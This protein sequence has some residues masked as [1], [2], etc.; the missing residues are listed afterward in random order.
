[1]FRSIK[2]RIY[3]SSSPA[4]Q[5]Q[6]WGWPAKAAAACAV[7][8]GALYAPAALAT[9]ICTNG[10]MVKESNWVVTSSLAG[11]ANNVSIANA[12]FSQTTSV[13]QAVIGNQVYL[14]I[15]RPPAGAYQTI[16]LDTFPGLGLRLSFAGYVNAGS[17]DLSPNGFNSLVNTVIANPVANFGTSNFSTGTAATSRY[18]KFLWRMDLVVTDVRVYAGGTGDFMRENNLS[19][20]MTSVIPIIYDGITRQSCYNT[21]VSFQKALAAGGVIALPELP[22]PPTPTCQFP[23]NSMTQSIPLKYGSTAAVPTVGSA[24]SLGVADETRFTIQANQCGANSNYRIYFTDANNAGSTEDYLQTTGALAGKVNLRMF[25]GSNST[26]IPYGPAP[27]GGTL[28][29]R[30]PGVSNSNTPANSSFLHDFYVQYVRAPGYVGDISGGTLS[31]KTTA[32]VVY[33]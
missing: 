1:M 31:G 15:A 12:T 7:T 22:K 24:R 8:A 16:P 30:A 33:P 20:G 5:P 29:S 18:L 14:L 9:P 32:T 21:N 19:Q 10:D 4:S 28:P 25:E 26:A 17:A 27:L 11:I 23:V 13:S 6:R 3:P 2:A